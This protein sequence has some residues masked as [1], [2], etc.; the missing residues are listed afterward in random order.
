MGVVIV[1]A[2]HCG[3]RVAQ[4]LRRS[5]Y[6]GSITLIGSE[7]HPPYERPPLSKAALTT[8]W[9]TASA[10]VLSGA[11][12]AA[13]DIDWRP[14][15]TVTAIDCLRHR[16]ELA[17]GAGLAFGALV[18]TT[19]AVPLAFS[20]SGADLPGVHILRT[21][22]QAVALAADLV[23]GKR[24]VV[25]GAG[26]T[27]LEV[28]SAAS[29][30]G[31]DVTVLEAADRPLAR[32]LPAE[33]AAA[34]AALHQRHGVTIRC[35]SRVARFSGTDRVTGVVLETGEHLPAD[36][37]LVAIGIR[38][39]TE[40]AEVAGLV[41]DDGIVT[42][43]FGRTSHKSVWAAGDCARG[44]NLRYDRAIRL[45]SWKNTEHQAERLAHALAGKPVADDVVPW[46][47]TEHFDHTVQAVGFPAAPDQV[48][49]RLDGAVRVDFAFR[50]GRLVGAAGLAPG[51]RITQ[52]IRVAQALLE[53]G[54]SP[55]PGLLADPTVKLLS[56]LK[57]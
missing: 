53:A 26:L 57:G 38:P 27:G 29:I 25:V 24:L 54:L 41:C 50:N 55:D 43:A 10:T 44:M 28:A 51:V 39:D 56:L 13:M 9:N 34:V 32:I 49:T 21:I 37:V 15:Q 8:D 18:L 20:V 1:G 4:G 3:G 16:V 42:D 11:A 19:G 17:D 22:D 12:C 45:E 46:F 6:D 35:G 31:C 33:T 5:G 36:S 23:A 2:G 47:W 30:R 48:A 52:E 40:L 14:G 7:Q